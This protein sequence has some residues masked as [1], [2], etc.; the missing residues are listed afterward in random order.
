MARVLWHDAAANE[1]EVMV[2]TFGRKTGKPHRVTVWIATDGKRL[3]IRSGQGMKRDW[4]KNLVARAEATLDVGGQKV[5]VR[6]RHISDPAEA[7]AVSR[8]V[9]KKYGAVVKTSDPG[10]PLTPAEEA[11][12]ELIPVE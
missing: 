10:E 7:R 5:H 9:R 3:F 4:P 8:L 11:S 1:R 2:T 12:F 6:A